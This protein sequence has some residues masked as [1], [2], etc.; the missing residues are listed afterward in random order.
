VFGYLALSEGK[1]LAYMPF[2]GH[3]SIDELIELGLVEIAPQTLVGEP[4]YRLTRAGND[5]H[6]ELTRLKLIPLQVRSE[7][8]AGRQ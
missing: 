1:S 7:H 5:M 3:K 4:R 2:V 8:L 6:Q